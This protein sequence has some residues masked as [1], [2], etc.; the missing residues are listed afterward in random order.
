MLP[1]RL[2][3]LLPT[4]RKYLE[5]M[6]Y[7]QF[8]KNVLETFLITLSLVGIVLL[9]GQWLLQEHFNT[10]AQN[11]TAISSQHTTTNQTIANINQTIK[12]IDAIEQEYI[13]WT[14]LLAS[15]LNILPSSVTLT[16]LD[17]DMTGKSITFV[18][19]VTSREELL[20]LEQQLE[21][22]ELINTAVIPISQLT[23]KNDIPFSIIATLK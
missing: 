19:H 18:G 1:T 16:S 17:V 9:G 13:L 3:L 11:I 14:P 10:L 23:Q 7:I 21:S 20:N 15:F 22:H 6:V 5:R 2:N 12:Q 4:K 8:G